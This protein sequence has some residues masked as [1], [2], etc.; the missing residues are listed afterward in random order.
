MSSNPSDS[1]SAME[2]Q[3][4]SDDTEL[5]EDRDLVD[6]CLEDCSSASGTGLSMH[7][8]DSLTYSFTEDVPSHKKVYMCME[9]EEKKLKIR[10][11][12]RQLRRWKSRCMT[13]RNKV[14]I[15]TKGF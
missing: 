1:S 12:N 4:V 6:D 9:C 2:K 3:P 14:C 11:L 13:L 5:A 8:A 7:Q 10:T 15:T